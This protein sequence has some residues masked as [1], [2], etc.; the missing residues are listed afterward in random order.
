MVRAAS[1]AIPSRERMQKYIERLYGDIYIY[2]YT[3]VIGGYMGRYRVLGF[4][5]STIGGFRCAGPWPS[6]VELRQR[7]ESCH[8]KGYTVGIMEKMEATI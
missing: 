6:L 3:G 5:A 4:K 7:K 1:N 8:M 2:T